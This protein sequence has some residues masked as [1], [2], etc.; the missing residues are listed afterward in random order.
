M[1][2]AA[3]QHGTVGSYVTGF[4]LSLLFTAMSYYLVVNK[5]LTGSSLLLTIVGFAVVQVVVQVFFFL[6]LGRGPKPL[7]N[8][9]F[10]GATVSVIGLVVGGSL[11]IMSHLQYNMAPPVDTAKQLAESEA[12]SQVEGSKTGAC[13]AIKANHKFTI[14]NGMISPTHI[15]AHLCDTLSFV[16]Q[17]TMAHE[18]S[19]GTRA[20]LKTYGGES[21][22]SIR[23]G[24]SE[25]ITL[26][27]AGEYSFY[28]SMYH[29]GTLSFTVQSR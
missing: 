7:Y 5:T 15:E 23:K 19:F 1:S 20:S 10:F 21:T 22:V 18:I 28:D 26:N 24:K 8:V 25:T 2:K 27:Q 4:I 13:E 6:H 16:N 17:D 9:I 12:I 11:F 14:D 3:H 29:G